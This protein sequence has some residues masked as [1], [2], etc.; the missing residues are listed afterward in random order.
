MG[1]ARAPFCRHGKKR[2]HAPLFTLRIH[3][4]G[5]AIDSHQQGIGAPLRRVE[6]RRFLLGR[7][8]F[9][10]DINVV[11][12]LHCV[13]VRSPHAHAR[14]HAIDVS[15]AVAAPGVVAVLSGEDM[16]A[17]GIKAMR[18]LWVIASRDGSPMAEP[19][20]FALARGTVR[21]VGEPIAA[22]IATTR[23]QAMDGAER[24]RVDYET[25][26]AVVDVRAAQAVSA[27]QLH[28]GVP[29]NVC[30]RWARG[31]EAHVRTVFV[32]AAHVIALEL[33][34]NRV[35]GAAIEPRAVLAACGPGIEKLTLYSSTQVP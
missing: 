32:S 24:V 18:P 11:D 17:D 28:A 19:P 21:H 26:P 1:P 20:R 34:N 29:G 5:V 31:D 6:D 35:A 15:A 8:R 25:L 9:V 30:F 16:A 4:G 14:I 13:L 33:I 7:G 22:V 3:A 23:E 2:S 27:P 10:A 12:A